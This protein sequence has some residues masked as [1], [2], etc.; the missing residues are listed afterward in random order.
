MSF[1]L[2]NP[3]ILNILLKGEDL[4]DSN[5]SL[6]MKRWLN[7]EISD[8]VLLDVEALLGEN[9]RE[10]V[11]SLPEQTGSVVTNYVIFTHHDVSVGNVD[12]LTIGEQFPHEDA[13]NYEK[14]WC[15]VGLS[16]SSKI[17]E[18][19]YLIYDAGTPNR[20]ENEISQDVLDI[21][22]MSYSQAQELKELCGI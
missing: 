19:F 20:T 13:T 3:E 5:A 11:S 2:S 9:S 22:G 15:Y 21:L 6:L 17:S 1:K 14:A 18:T 4:D 12:K 7:D 16:S 8:D 10:T